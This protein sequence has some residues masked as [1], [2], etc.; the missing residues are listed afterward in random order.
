VFAREP[1]PPDH[2]FWTEPNITVTSHLS[3]LTR[4]AEAVEY[5]L[6]NLGRFERGEPLVGVVDRSRGY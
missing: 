4:P 5:F 6:A 1:L 3:G 2:P